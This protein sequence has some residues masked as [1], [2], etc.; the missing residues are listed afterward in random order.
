MVVE[1]R[2]GPVLLA[3]AGMALFLGG[4]VNAHAAGVTLTVWHNTQDTPGV[5]GLY[6]AYEKA[7]GNTLSLVD[8][9]A[10]GFEAATLTKWASGD[11]PDIL[12]YHPGAS[13][14]D[15]FNPSQNFIDLSNE[16]FVKQSTIYDIGGRAS[17]GKVYAAITTFPEVWGLYYNKKVLADHGLK[18]ATTFDEVKA[19][20]AALS[21]VG[22]ATMHEAGASMW[23]VGVDPLIYASTIA[24]PGYVADV[25]AHKA[26]FNDPDSPMLAGFKDWSERKA[27]GCFNSDMTTA[28]FEGGAKAVYEGKAAYQLIHSNI[29]AVYLDEA[30]N[31]KAK[32]DE[33][34]GFVAIGAKEQKTTVDAGPIGSYMLPKTGDNAK[35]AAALD[36][37]RFVTGPGYADYIKASG[38]FPIVNGVPD[39]AAS[40]LMKDIKAAYDKGPRV[41]LMNQNVP[42]AFSGGLQ[43]AS[44]HAVGQLTSQQAVDQLQQGVVEAAQAQGLSGW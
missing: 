20:C 41:T 3:A 36:F 8:V 11:R 19:Q 9:P 5:L 2:R 33:K 23:P 35:Q 24:R 6:K 32:L 7:S 12:E 43:V 13:D 14:L 39:P 17:D 30:G 42:G 26:K 22:I 1:L 31:D 29:A 10:D 38:T 18:P 28:T 40:G 27:A 16:A 44:E 15:H 21:K 34:V 25:L 4:A 37:V